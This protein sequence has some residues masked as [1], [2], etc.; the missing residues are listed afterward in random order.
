[1]PASSKYI[2]PTKDYTDA[3]SGKTIHLEQNKTYSLDIRQDGPVM[4]VNGQRVV[5]PDATIW[6]MFENGTIQMPYSIEALPKQWEGLD[7]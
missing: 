2:G 1:M 5:H 6:L 4:V 3:I 7:A